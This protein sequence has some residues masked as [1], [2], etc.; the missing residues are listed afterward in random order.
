MA[1]PPDD[2]P[3]PGTPSKGTTIDDL[4]PRFMAVAA[5]AGAKT[6]QRFIVKFQYKPPTTAPPDKARG[7]FSTAATTFLSKVLLTHGGDVSFVSIADDTL[8]DLQSMPTKS[9]ADCQLWFKLVERPNAYRSQELWIKIETGLSFSA[10]KSPLFDYLTDNDYWLDNEDYVNRLCSRRR[11]TPHLP[12][13][14]PSI[15]EPRS[16]SSPPEAPPYRPHRFIQE[17][18]LCRHYPRTRLSQ[19]S[20]YPSQQRQTPRR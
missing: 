2:P 10:F 13:R 1:P 4:S 9:D 12:R 16:S 20:C 14:L 17:I 19:N 6:L 11:R 3:D 15:C 8:I 5:S 7:H 18:P